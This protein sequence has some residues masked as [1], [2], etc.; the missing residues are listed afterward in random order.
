LKVKLLATVAGLLA[1][2]CVLSATPFSNGSFESGVDPGVLA[3][4]PNGSTA[5]SNWIVVGGG[6]VDYIG[7]YWQAAQGTRS[8]DLNGSGPAML[9]QTFDTII[10]IPYTVT[11]ALAGNPDGPPASKDIRVTAALDSATFTFDVTNTTIDAMGWVYKTFTFTPVA[12][13]TTLTFESFTQGGYGPAI[14]D[15]SVSAAPEPG[16][17]AMLLG[18]LALGLVGL[19]RKRVN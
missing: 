7:T 3:A 18:G 15:V 11:F 1:G 2:A 5:I 9:S 19:R 10:N 13:T 8:V 17:T 12:S 4:L 14:D 16:T 6:G